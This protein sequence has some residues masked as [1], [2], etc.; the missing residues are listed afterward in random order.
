MQTNLRGRKYT[1]AIGMLLFPPAVFSVGTVS[2]STI[3]LET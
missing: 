3:K 2:P 1:S